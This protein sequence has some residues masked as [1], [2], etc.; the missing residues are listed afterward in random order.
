[1]ALGSVQLQAWMLDYVAAFAAPAAPEQALRLAGAVHSLRLRVGGGM[2]LGP[3]EID[4]A[5]TVAKRT[6]DDATLDRA[7]AEGLAMTL[8]E[9][10]GYARNLAGTPPKRL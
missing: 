2:R 4:D 10:V 5:K 3:V 8:D 9:A 7:W 1:M 6:L